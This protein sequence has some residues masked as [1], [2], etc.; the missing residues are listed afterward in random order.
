M[1]NDNIIKAFN[2]KIHIKATCLGD[3]YAPVKYEIKSPLSK[4][5][6]E[7]IILRYMPYQDLY[8]YT[9][10]QDKTIDNVAINIYS[11]DYFLEI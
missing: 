5:E 2:N 8:F 7:K 9:Y 3:K 4:K 10:I 6:A 11:A 1:N